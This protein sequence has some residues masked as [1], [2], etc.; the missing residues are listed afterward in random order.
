MNDHIFLK[1]F[2]HIDGLIVLA[3]VDYYDGSVLDS[4]GDDDVN[5]DMLALEG[6]AI[7]KHQK[8]LIKQFNKTD[9]V[10]GILISMKNQYH[11]IHPLESNHSL[12]LY[13]IL[14]RDH[15]NLAYAHHEIQRLERHLNFY[16]Y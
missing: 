4:I 2:S 5:I 6:S 3:L 9:Y 13:V 15:S 16:A 11:I 1:Q 14:D 7:F 10:E 12:F 8:K